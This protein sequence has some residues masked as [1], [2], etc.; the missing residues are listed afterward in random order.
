MYLGEIPKN[1]NIVISFDFFNKH[2][3]FSTGLLPE[4]DEKDKIGTIF[5][6]PIVIKGSPLR[7]D[8]RCENPEIRYLNQLSGRTHVWKKVLIRYQREYGG[9][10]V[11]NCESDSVPENRRRAVRIA[12]NGKSECVLS[13]LKGK[14]PCTISDIS[15]TGVGLTIDV[16]LAEKNPLHRT[17]S[18]HFRDDIIGVDFQIQARCIHYSKSEGNTARCG[19]EIISVSPS[20]NEYIN[21]RQTH[22]LARMSA[23]DL[24]KLL[25]VS[26]PNKKNL[27]AISDDRVPDENGTPLPEPSKP[28]SAG[29]PIAEGSVCPICEEGRLRRYGESF[30]CDICGSILDNDM[31]DN[32]SK[33]PLFED[34]PILVK[35]GGICPVCEEGKLHFNNGAYECYVCGSILEK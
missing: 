13:D 34:N 29:E 23:A 22:R 4:E 25:G 17:I 30:E 5:S 14:Y 8:E 9:Y 31:T 10:Y 6:E 26:I 35:N 12:I 19:C 24:E 27:P 1:E 33:H 16:A 11:L 21:L 15:V 3:D 28:L 18:T 7:L 2:F 20:I 32:A